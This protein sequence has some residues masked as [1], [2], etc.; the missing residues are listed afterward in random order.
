MNRK[1]TLPAFALALSRGSP[2][3]AMQWLERLEDETERK[4]LQLR[5]LQHWRQWDAEGAAAWLSQSSLR[6]EGA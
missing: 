2:A 1:L 5:I 3:E 4:N 6:P